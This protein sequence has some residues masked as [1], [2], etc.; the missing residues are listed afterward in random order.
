MMTKPKGIDIIFNFLSDE[1]LQAAF[2]ALV[3]HGMFFNFSKFD[4]KNRRY[5]GY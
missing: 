5:L 4:M 1:S 2:R 3:D